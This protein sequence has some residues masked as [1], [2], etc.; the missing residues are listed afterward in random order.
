MKIKLK[1]ILSIVAATFILLSCN[2]APQKKEANKISKSEVM[3][4]L[5]QVECSADLY[6]TVPEENTKCKIDQLVN[7]NARYFAKGNYKNGEE[8]GVIFVDYKKLTPLNFSTKDEKYYLI[9]FIVSNQ[10]SGSFYYLGLFKLNKKKVMSEHLSSFFLGDR[11]KIESV[12]QVADNTAEISIKIHSGG[13]ALS[14]EPSETK[15]ILVKVNKNGL[16]ER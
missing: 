7:Q 2:N 16:T 11:I 6:V 4:K 13:Q 1:I 8:R 3:Q 15:I 9:P 12:K 14:E 10:G 5:F